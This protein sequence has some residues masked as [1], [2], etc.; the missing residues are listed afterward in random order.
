MARLYQKCCTCKST[1]VAIQYNE[2]PTKIFGGLHLFF[3]Y[4][5][6]FSR[7]FPILPTLGVMLQNYVSCFQVEYLR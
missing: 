2:K 5:I 1:E 4:S 7:S 3:T 6:P